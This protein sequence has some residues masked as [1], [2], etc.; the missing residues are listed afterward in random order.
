MRRRGLRG[1]AVAVG[2]LLL[3]LA[4]GTTQGTTSGTTQN[5]PGVT[6]KEILIGTTTPLSGAASAYASVSKGATAYFAYLNA[7]GGVNG[8]TITYRIYDD[9]YDPAKSVPLVRQLLTQDNVF[10]IFNELGTP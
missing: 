3:S 4:C 6:D 10:A 7:K 2:A 1:L 5:V 9:A 8:R